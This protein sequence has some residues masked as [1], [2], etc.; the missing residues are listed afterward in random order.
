MAMF[1]Q[2]LVTLATELE[3]KL[4]CVNDTELPELYSETVTLK[5]QILKRFYLYNS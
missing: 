3:L 1:W 5:F 2:G 4:F